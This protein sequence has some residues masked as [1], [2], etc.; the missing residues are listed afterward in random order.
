MTNLV[1]ILAH[2]GGMGMGACIFWTGTNLSNIISS[3]DLGDL[4]QK[5]QSWIS[6]INFVSQLILQVILKS[7]PKFHKH[8]FFQLG[9]IAAGPIAGVI[10]E[11]FG[12][13][14]SI[15]ILTLPCVLGWL[16]M[17]CS[18]NVPMICAGRF[19]TGELNS[20]S[21]NFKNFTHPG[22]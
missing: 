4:S 9:A 19:I 13:K 2:I 15:Q 8:S 10:L 12:R 21:D 16:L 3:G 20:K 1:S 14:K 17:A 22:V 7:M 6:S 18:Y 5:E 11:K